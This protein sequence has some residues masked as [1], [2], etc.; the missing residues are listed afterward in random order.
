MKQLLIVILLFVSVPGYCY[1][2]FIKQ[3]NPDI[4]DERAANI[5][6]SVQ[7]FSSYYDIPS[8]VI[9]AIMW[10]ETQ[11]V[12]GYSDV[13][14]NPCSSGYMQIQRTTASA[15]YHQELTCKELIINWRL[16]IQLGVKYLRKMY[17]HT[18]H[19]AG[20]IGRY[21]GIHNLDY[22]QDVLNKREKVIEWKR[23]NT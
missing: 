19:L 5:T 8:E 16:N 18:G 15:I 21:N 10:Q 22:V 13:D 12:N 9:I 6:R 7:H 20:A 14:R 4:P 23:N 17:D 2:G 1:T 11:F 3:K